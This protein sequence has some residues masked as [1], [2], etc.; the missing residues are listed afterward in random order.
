MTTI[1]RAAPQLHRR[2]LLADEIGSSCRLD[3]MEAAD[4]IAARYQN[5]PRIRRLCATVV[6][7]DGCWLTPRSRFGSSSSPC[8]R[9]VVSEPE[10]EIEDLQPTADRFLG[11]ARS[12]AVKE[13]SG[14]AARSIGLL[15]VRVSIQLIRSG[16]TPTASDLAPRPASS[17]AWIGC[18]Q[19]CWTSSSCAAGS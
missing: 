16:A 15:G 4:R 11:P 17:A 9:P 5:E 13:K 2:T 10:G 12:A 18:A 7:V 6:P 1:S 8:S 3:A 19:S 14:A